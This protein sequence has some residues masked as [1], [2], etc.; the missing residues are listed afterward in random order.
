MINRINLEYS[1][2]DLRRLWNL[3]TIGISP[4]QEKALTTGDSQ[5]LLEF[6]ESY[7]IDVRKVVRLPNKFKCELAPNRG[8]AERSFRALY[9]RLHRAL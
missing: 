2:I 4:S 1:D 6:R 3:E 8:T 7:H 5:I 9:K